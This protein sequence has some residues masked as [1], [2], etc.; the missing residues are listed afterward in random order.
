MTVP[1]SGPR[2]R[3]ATLVDVARE[4]GVSLA[5][6]S[7]VING[8]RFVSDETKQRVLRAV[9][10]LNYE[11]NSVARSLK[12]NRSQ[13]IGLLISD[14]S[15]P[16][17]TSLVRAVEDVAHGAGYSVMLCNTDE[18]PAKELRY[19]HVL[20]QKRVD[21]VLI[22]PTGSRHRYLE[23]LIESGFPVVCFDRVL[24]DLRCDA[25]TLDNVGGAHQAV[26]HLIRLGHRR[27]GIIAG[28]ARVGTTA[29][30]LTGYRRALAEY[31]IQEEPELVRGADGRLDGGRQQAETLLDLANPP[32]A[33]F[34]TNNLMT[35]GALVALQ[36]RGIRVPD[37]V[38]LVGFDD[39][40]WTVVLQPRLTTVAQPTYDIG[41]I[42]ARM[43]I[44]RVEHRT[45]D[46][47]RRVIL[48]PHL[49]V[50]QSC[51]SGSVSGESEPRRPA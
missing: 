8:T 20:R 39:F 9:E 6:A 22:A 28:L 24:P 12:R 2:P 10:S 40:E 17:F 21:G 16:Y 18:D 14:I 30:R 29:E 49:I 7:H 43:L 27:I 23:H 42:A 19:L 1:S 47:P 11:I 45:S 5:T 31:G 44:E 36:L 51:G 37:D 41:K 32:S 26:C 3:P 15:N 35:L 50:R 38:S 34:A 46:G 25:V 4:A 48:P 33:I 13:V